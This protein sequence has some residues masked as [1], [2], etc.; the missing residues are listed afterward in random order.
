MLNSFVS[1]FPN[2]ANNI[3]VSQ[4]CYRFFLSENFVNSLFFEEISEQEVINLCSS[5]RSGT[6]SGSDNVPMSLIK[7]TII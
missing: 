7:E 3:P 6:V 4:K 2:L 5:F 1:I